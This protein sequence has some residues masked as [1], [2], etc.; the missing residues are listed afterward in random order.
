MTLE[1]SIQTF[2]LRVPAGGRAERE[3]QCDVSALRDLAG[4]CSIGGAGA[5][6]SMGPTAC[7]RNGGRR[8]GAGRPSSPSSRNAG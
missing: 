6:R 7:I 1:D 2:R 8:G 4:P 3:H 5:S